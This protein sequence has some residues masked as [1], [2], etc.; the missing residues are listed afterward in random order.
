QHLRV[1][2]PFVSLAD[3]AQAIHA[4]PPAALFDAET[5]L[6]PTMRVDAAGR[7]WVVSDLGMLR[8]DDAA[9]IDD[10]SVADALLATP[11]TAFSGETHDA[12]DRAFVAGGFGVWIW[13]Q[14]STR[15]DLDADFD[16]FLP[17]DD[18]THVIVAGD[19][20]VVA[21]A[22][23]PQLALYDAATVSALDP[24]PVA[25]LPGF[26]D[27]WRLYVRGNL[28][29]VIDTAKLHVIDLDSLEPVGE[30]A[31]DEDYEPDEL[32]YS[33][34]HNLYL[35]LP[36]G[37]DVWSDVPENPSHVAFLSGDGEALGMALQECFGDGDCDEGSCVSGL[38]RP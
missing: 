4:L 13:E 22:N 35:R 12:S 30:L 14:A 6:R 23:Q 3:D 17:A 24:D 37:V 21:E 7:L 33:S 31:Y 2:E 38:C 10:A 5:V 27:P 16:E 20:L 34:K 8:F 19:R 32:I 29:F 15:I 26:T 9:A 36:D 18:P 25:L 11:D 28:L 1:Y